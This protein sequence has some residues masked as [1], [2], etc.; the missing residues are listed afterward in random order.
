MSPLSEISVPHIKIMAQ[1]DKR[2]EIYDYRCFIE[3]TQILHI[4]VNTMWNRSVSN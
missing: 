1:L 3:P 4:H 2:E